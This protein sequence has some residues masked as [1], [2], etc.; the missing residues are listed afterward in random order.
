MKKNLFWLAAL[1]LGISCA[2]WTGCSDDDKTTPEP[3]PVPPV[4][5][6]PIPPVKDTTWVVKSVRMDDVKN[7]GFYKEVLLT[8]TNGKVSSFTV[9]SHSPKGLNGPMRTVTVARSTGAVTLTY[10]ESET[11]IGKIV[12]SLNAKGCPTNVKCYGVDEEGD[13]LTLENT[14]AYNANGM[15]E[16]IYTLAEMGE[17][18]NGDPII[19]EFDL[20]K[21]TF[22]ADS[23]WA[24]CLAS[25]EEGIIATCKYSS[26]KN[27]YSI[28]LNMLNVAYS[29]SED[30]D[31][32]ILLGLI[33]ATSKVLESIDA[34]E[35]IITYT[36]TM[37]GKRIASVKTKLGKDTANNVVLGY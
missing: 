34:G 8:Q 15:L 9:A 37:D 24:S 10:A 29:V 31:Y 1:M 25:A 2:L 23:T 3:D 11:I 35:G 16:R 19:E 17:D 26:I 27:N 28:D 21:V 33:P 13:Y 4:D 22:A 12:Y 20:F 36:P 6:T 5:T 7:E 32:A 30:I 18:D 14:Y